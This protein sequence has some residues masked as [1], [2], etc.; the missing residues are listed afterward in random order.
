MIYAPIE[1]FLAIEVPESLYIVD[2]IIPLGS[3][4]II[5]GDT[6]V[7][8]SMVGLTLAAAVAQGKPFL[9]TFPVM[10][11]SV[12][13]VQLDMPVYEW[14]ERLQTTTGYFPLED[15]TNPFTMLHFDKGEFDIMSPSDEQKHQIAEA[16]DQH[17]PAL[18]IMDVIADAHTMD[19]V[20]GATPKRYYRAC[21]KLFGPEVSM[22]HVHHQRKSQ[23]GA[24]N[25]GNPKHSASGHHAFV[26]PCSAALQINEAA[27]NAIEDIWVN[28][29]KNPRNREALKSIP[30][31]RKAGWI[32]A[33]RSDPKPAR[34][35]ELIEEGLS[36]AQI[37]PIFEEEFGVKRSMTQRLA[38]AARRQES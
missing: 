18:I 11:S 34:M 31:M 1:D 27:D 15:Y 12:L 25:Q 32:E 28:F 5:Y 23:A 33:I 35:R 30:C 6:G 26:D 4:V 17:N 8:K 37:V 22:V 38:K 13:Y 14:Q 21:R 24:D 7:G 16:L 10:E 2:P 20:S 3:D 36:N 19:E 9:G 29:A